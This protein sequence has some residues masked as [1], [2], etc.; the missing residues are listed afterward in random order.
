MA[1]KL[2]SAG[3]V[4]ERAKKKK[5]QVKAPVQKPDV[6]FFKDPKTGETQFHGA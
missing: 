1:R 3:A 2:T 5:E 6:A 4:N